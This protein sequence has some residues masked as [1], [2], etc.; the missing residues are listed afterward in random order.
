M[1]HRAIFFTI[2]VLFVVRVGYASNNHLKISSPSSGVSVFTGMNY[3]H[4]SL[5]SVL[6]DMP[7]FIDLSGEKFGRLTV[8]CRTAKTTH[9]TRWAC[10]CECGNIA[11]VTTLYLRNGQI[12]SCGCLRASMKV[13]LVSHG[14]TKTP[15]YALWR[16]IKSRCNNPNYHAWPYYGGKGVKMCNE[17][18]NDF[19]AFFTWINSNGYKRGLQIDRI[20]G[21]GD[22]SPSNCR[23]VTAAENCAPGRRKFKKNKTGY[24]GVSVTKGGSY[25]IYVTIDKKRRYLGVVKTLSDAVRL[26]DSH[27]DQYIHETIQNPI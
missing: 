13:Y 24:T 2:F 25:E 12:K 11:S 18:N 26:R 27:T 22:Y 14:L 10:I 4:R 16:S 6:F 8:L 17:W 9:H 3:E 19:M 1:A 15:E 20:N 5:G 21:D 23:F 7:N